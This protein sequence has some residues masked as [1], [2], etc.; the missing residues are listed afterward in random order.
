MTTLITDAPPPPSAPN[1]PM[2]YATI[3]A[4]LLPDEVIA[5]R[6]LAE[7]KRRIGIGLAALLVLLLV[8]YGYSWWQTS[9]AQGDLASARHGTTALQQKQNSYLPLVTAQTQSAAIQTALRKLMVGDLSW[10][11]M[12]GVLAKEGAKNGIVIADISGTLTAGAVS[13]STQPGSAGFSVLNQTGK[14]S[15]GTMSI[16]GTAPD[17]SAVAAFVDNLSKVPGLAA[18]FPASV[19]SVN[20]N[21][22][23]SVLYTLSVIITSDALGGRYAQPTTGGK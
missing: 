7:L 20:D 21:G 9:S 4:N 14:Q 12:L 17:K 19:T 11:D 10:T 6:R 3:R 8:G 16:V 23:G 5:S 22:V 18:P 15:V 2:R 13:G 1:A